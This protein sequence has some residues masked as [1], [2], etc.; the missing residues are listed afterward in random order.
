MRRRGK[1]PWLE[2]EKNRVRTAPTQGIAHRLADGENPL[3][4]WRIETGLSVR[5]LDRKTG[6]AAYDLTCMEQGLL[7]PTLE[8]LEKIAAALRVIPELLMQRPVES[9]D[10][11]PS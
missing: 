1:S 8:E 2:A 10:G 3:A 7:T 9:A 4:V 5:Q 6:I 11:E